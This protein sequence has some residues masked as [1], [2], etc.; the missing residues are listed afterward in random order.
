MHIDYSAQFSGEKSS[1]VAGGGF[2]QA[3]RG[4]KTGRAA[5]A[6]DEGGSGGGGTQGG[7][8]MGAHQQKGRRKVRAQ[9]SFS[10]LVQLQALTMER[11][12]SIHVS[13]MTYP[14]AGRSLSLQFESTLRACWT[15]AH[16]DQPKA[17]C[18][19]GA[20]PAQHSS[21]VRA[22]YEY[23]CMCRS[24]RQARGGKLAVQLTRPMIGTGKR[25]LQVAMGIV[26]G[27]LTAGGTPI[28]GIRCL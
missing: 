14:Y 18:G 22:P 5:Q 21:G 8:W 24:M 7:R 1:R 16:Y 12:R 9:S 26:A 19:H 28:G 20:P 17:P 15:S 6:D 4:R 10:V 27:Q 23:I 2:K 11:G 25:G 13:R 3:K